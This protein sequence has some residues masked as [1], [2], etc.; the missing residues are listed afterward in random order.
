M[1]ETI[2]N[3]KILNYVRVYDKFKGY[4]VCV[5]QVDWNRFHP[6]P[7]TLDDHILL[8]HYQCIVLNPCGRSTETRITIWYGQHHTCECTDIKHIAE[9]MTDNTDHSGTVVDKQT[10]N[11]DGEDAKDGT[12]ARHN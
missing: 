11:N 12:K 1:N 3:I 6:I 2:T 5:K 4:I 10:T 8:N 7:Y 9:D